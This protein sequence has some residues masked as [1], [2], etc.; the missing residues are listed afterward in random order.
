LP[1]GSAMASLADHDSPMLEKVPSVD[2]LGTD[3]LS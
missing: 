2:V 1:C 3:Q